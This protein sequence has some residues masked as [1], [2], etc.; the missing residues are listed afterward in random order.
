MIFFCGV[1]IWLKF[2]LSVVLV[3]AIHAS[4]WLKSDLYLR[5]RIEDLITPHYWSCWALLYWPINSYFYATESRVNVFVIFKNTALRF[6]YAIWL[7]KIMQIQ[8]SYKL[9]SL[10]HD[11]S[12][13]MC[14]SVNRVL[15]LV[16]LGIHEMY[17]N[18]NRI[19]HSQCE[20][21]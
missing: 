8:S 5:Y 7:V 21:Y 18:I 12:D 13:P 4:I 20:N 11:L 3:V 17:W 9:S 2:S 6:K 16:S 10:E 19:P 1:F 14:D 15:T